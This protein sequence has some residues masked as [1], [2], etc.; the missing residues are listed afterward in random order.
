MV[1]SLT[2]LEMMAYIKGKIPN[3]ALIPLYYLEVTRKIVIQG[4]LGTAMDYV[5]GRILHWPLIFPSPWYTHL[6][7]YWFNKRLSCWL[8]VRE[9]QNVWGHITRNYRLPLDAKSNIWPISSKEMGA[10][11]L[12]MQANGFFQKH[13]WTWQYICLWNLHKR[14]YPGWYPKCEVW[15][16]GLSQALLDLWPTELWDNEWILFSGIV[17]TNLLWRIEN[18]PRLEFPSWLSG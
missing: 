5:I 9:I 6:F 15:S 16:R 3:F 12:Q 14:V 7:L 18:S 2:Y 8:Y 13:E 4:W 11:V 1:R 10:S 17:S